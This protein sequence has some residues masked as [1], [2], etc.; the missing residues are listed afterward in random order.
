MSKTCAFFGNRHVSDETKQILHRTLVNLIESGEV[1][2]F[3][4]GNQGGFDCMVRQELRELKQ[5][6]QDIDYT[7]VLAYMPGKKDDYAYDDFSDTVFPDELTHVP[8][9]FAIDKRNRL[10]IERSDIIITYVRY[11]FGGAA[12]FKDIAIKK[13]KRVIEI[14]R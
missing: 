8:P 9:R 11:S 12:K 3:L 1:K 2:K 14:C 6:Y 5:L 13:G 4:V 7:V 10:L